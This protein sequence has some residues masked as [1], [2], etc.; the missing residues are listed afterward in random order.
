MFI[1][2]CM[3]EFIHAG[4]HV[5]VY[6]CAFSLRTDLCMYDVGV[7]MHVYMHEDSA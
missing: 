7:R 5:H 3:Y 2:A 4:S 6:V 1:D